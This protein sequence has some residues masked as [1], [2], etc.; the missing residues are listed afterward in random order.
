MNRLNWFDGSGDRVTGPTTGFETPLE[1]STVFFSSAGPN[2]DGEVKPDLVAP[3]ANVI[4]AMSV[5]AHPETNEGSVFVAPGCSPA[6]ACGVADANHAV[7]SGSSMSAPVVAGAIALLFEQ[8]PTLTQEDVRR[9]L[10]AGARPLE[11]NVRIDQ[12]V[13]AGTLDLV[14]TL[15]AHAESA[16]PARRTP[17]TA[18]RIILSRTYAEPDADRP[19]TGLLQIRDADGNVADGFDE[20]DLRLAATPQASP[21]NLRRQ[22]PGL[23]RFS[24]A[25]PAGSGGG[26]LKLELLFDGRLLAEAAV[27]IAVDASVARHGTFASGGCSVGR[28]GTPCVA[29]R[30]K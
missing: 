19:I 21:P 6:P 30:T 22:A 25:A 20:A 13:G 26:D 23:W 16:E 28:P 14:R 18:S 10:Q 12:Q 15:Q 2:V 24:V 4:A 7:S 29:S 3:G 11:G 17:G 1:D 27:P 8:D 9:L 5:D